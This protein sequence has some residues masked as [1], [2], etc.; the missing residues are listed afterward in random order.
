VT[1]TVK[2]K[3]DPVAVVGEPEIVPEP[4][5]VKPGGRLPEVTAQ[6]LGAV[7]PDALRVVEG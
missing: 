3:G 2:A 6:V 4:L 7:P 5:N 1:V